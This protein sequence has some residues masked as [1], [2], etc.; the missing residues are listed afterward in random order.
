MTIKP[1]NP[2]AAEFVSLERFISDGPPIAN[3]RAKDTKKR[4]LFETVSDLR[5]MPPAEELIEGFIPER[6]IGLLYGKWGSFKTFIGFDWALHLAFGMKEWHGA[7]LP[8]KTCEVLIIAREGTCWILETRRCFQVAPRSN[9]RS[10]ETRLH[11][12]TYIVPGRCWVCCTQRGDH[13]SRAAVPVRP[14][15]Y[16]WPLPSWR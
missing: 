10:Q 1:P 15:R 5:S 16:R 9:G 14:G 4:F 7:K 13:G 8:G 12:Q 11:G 6:S 2:R 3:G